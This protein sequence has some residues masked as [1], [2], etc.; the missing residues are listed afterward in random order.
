MRTQPNPCS[1]IPW[2][3]EWPVV[4]SA[5]ILTGTELGPRESNAM[6]LC[7]ALVCASSPV[8]WTRVTGGE[9]ALPSPSLLQA[10]RQDDIEVRPTAE[11]QKPQRNREQ[12]C[13]LAM[14]LTAS[15][16]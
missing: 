5:V 3:R 4:F 7:R 6:G 11:M 14:R 16:A 10:V 2:L 12:S 13:A 15:S 8:L 9:G 1:L